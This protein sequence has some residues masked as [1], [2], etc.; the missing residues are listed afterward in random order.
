M[1]KSNL[2]GRVSL[3]GE[4]YSSDNLEGN[5]VGEG[6]VGNNLICD[7][8]PFFKG[9]TSDV[10]DHD[11]AMFGVGLS[12]EPY[13]AQQVMLLDLASTPQPVAKKWKRLAR[14][15]HTKSHNGNVEV[16]KRKGKW[17]ELEKEVIRS[18]DNSEGKN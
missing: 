5:F 17:I 3:E 13:E 14:A 1:L 8:T 9:L 10:M 12:K 4:L 15:P 16:G 7:E 2:M 18:L 6:A 11:G